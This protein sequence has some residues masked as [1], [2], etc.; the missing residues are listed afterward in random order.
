MRECS[1]E[2]V[3]CLVSTII[4]SVVLVAAISVTVSLALLVYLFFSRQRSSLTQWHLC[5][6]DWHP[7]GQGIQMSR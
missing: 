2:L 4:Y 1:P 7:R 3:W 5:I 6:D